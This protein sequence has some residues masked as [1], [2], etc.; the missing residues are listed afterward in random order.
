V[1]PTPEVEASQRITL[2]DIASDRWIPP[3]LTESTALILGKTTA[4]LHIVDEPSNW[5]ARLPLSN[6]TSLDGLLLLPLGVTSSTLV[7]SLIPANRLRN[8]EN[9]R[10]RVDVVVIDSVAARASG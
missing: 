2:T 4:C 6:G 1:K 5:V 7:C 8:C 10:P 3:A 9:S